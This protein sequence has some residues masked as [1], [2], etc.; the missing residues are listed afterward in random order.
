[1]G[2]GDGAEE[3]DA[4]R[5]TGARGDGEG[6]G[7]AVGPVGGVDAEYWGCGAGEEVRRLE[8]LD[9]VFLRVLRVFRVGARDEHAAVHEEDGFG[10]VEARDGRVGHHAY[11]LVYGL[12][13]VV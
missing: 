2:A 9:A 4:Q 12:A 7:L 3:R 5:A 1:M 10:V 13:G 8:H 11:A 6:D